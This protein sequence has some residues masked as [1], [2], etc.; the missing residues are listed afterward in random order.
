M[1]RRSIHRLTTI[2]TCA[3]FLALAASGAGVKETGLDR[4]VHAPDPNYKYELVKTIP[5]KGYT[6]YV[7]DMTSQAWRTAAEVN[8]PIW[9][10][11]LVIIKPDEV[12]TTTG[13]LFITGGSIDEK[14]PSRAN[15]LDVEMAM[16]TH[17]VVSE[18]RGIPNEPLVF[19]DDP[20]PRTEVL[21]RLLIA[22]ELHQ[23][24]GTVYARLRYSGTHTQRLVD[25]GQ[26]LGS[27]PILL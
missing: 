17:S 11:W 20:K 10:H 5:G 21:H 9:K 6:M 16:T 7:I 1:I 26:R 25:H 14:T 24:P 2:L 27:A 12:K 23:G 3:L 18:L 15:P 8:H 22:V 4:Y 19:A 13:F